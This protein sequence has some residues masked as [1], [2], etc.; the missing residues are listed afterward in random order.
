MIP[1]ME[2]GSG[3]DLHL[4][5]DYSDGVLTPAALMALV[6]ARGVGLAALTDHDTLAGCDE[7]RRACEPLGL[8]FVAGVEVTASWRAQELH[9]I[10]LAPRE[11]DSAL[12]AHLKD[13]RARRRQR[14][15]AIG[16]RLTQR[17]A[18]PVQPLIETLLQQYDDAGGRA[19]TRLHL[20]RALVAAGHARDVGDAFDHWLSR[21]TP[22][23]VPHEWPTLSQTLEVLRSAN[24]VAVLAHPHRYKLSAGALRQLVEEFGAAG[25]AAL[26]VSVG[27][28]A[29]HD[30]DRL[31]T[32]ARRHGLAASVGS[33]FHDPALPWNPPGR[34]AKLPDDLEPV[35]ARLR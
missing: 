22:G 17:G 16:E 2:P 25:G 13:I 24:A 35:T 33:D 5:S 14:L 11:D 28:M 3:L 10:G 8:R 32:L 34:F 6:A 31:A 9:V 18:L 1:T 12:A 26:E 15:I 30:L 21:G 27:G 23:H 4:H 20:A 29:R 19:P 7:A